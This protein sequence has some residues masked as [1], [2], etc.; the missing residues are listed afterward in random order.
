MGTIYE[1]VCVCVCV[2]V[3]VRVCVPLSNRIMYNTSIDTLY[4]LITRILHMYDVC[5]LYVYY[6]VHSKVLYIYIYIY[7]YMGGL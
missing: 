3:C 6:G 2:R 7:I 4:T 5:T 1:C